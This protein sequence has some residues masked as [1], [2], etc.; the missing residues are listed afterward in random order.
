ME[1]YRGCIIRARREDL[2]PMHLAVLAPATDRLAFPPEDD[3][4]EAPEEDEAAVCHDG[5]DEPEN[6]L[7]DTP[8]FRITD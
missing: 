4:E 2:H 3:A 1:R 5:W 8:L 6:G 7:V